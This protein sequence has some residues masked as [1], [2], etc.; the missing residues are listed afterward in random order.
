MLPFIR[1]QLPQI[2]RDVLAA[3][4][5]L[6]RLPVP[7]AQSRP[8]AA[9]AWPL[10]GLAVNALAL[11]LAALALKAGLSVGVVAALVIAAQAVLTGALHED[12][13]ADCADGFF[14][15]HTKER[16]LEIMKDSQIGSFG[17]L[18]LMLVV[19]AR[20]AALA[21]LLSLGAWGA[22]LA[23]GALARAPMAATMALVPNARGT[24]LSASVGAPPV[25]AAGIAACLALALALGLAGWSGLVMTVAVALVAL[26]VAL[27][28]RSKIGGQTGDVLGATA[29]LAEVCA[30]AVV[31]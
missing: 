10:V 24:G 17:A 20:W 9:W 31:G 30:L 27:V 14:G 8:A 5:L 13:L 18:A 4:G 22:I 3:F 26:A 28:A 29:V 1:D 15:G 2:P 19:L 12:G 11:G 23:A 16:R 7:F 25:W 21:A 6:S